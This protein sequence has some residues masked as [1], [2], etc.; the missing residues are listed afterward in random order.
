MGHKRPHVRLRSPLRDSTTAST[1]LE[2]AR[3]GNLK[4]DLHIAPG[5]DVFQVVFSL[6]G[7]TGLRVEDDETL[8]ETAAGELRHFETRELAGLSGKAIKQSR[9]TTE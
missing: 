6:H 2:R 9:C 7:T 1:S 8:I 5:A 3:S 4:Y